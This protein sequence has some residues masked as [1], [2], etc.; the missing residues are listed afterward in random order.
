MEFARRETA[1]EPI[2][3]PTAG[4]VVDDNDGD[5]DTADV[6][7][8]FNDDSNHATPTTNLN[9]AGEEEEAENRAV[10]VEK[11]DHTGSGGGGGRRACG[12][13][14]GC[15][16]WLRFGNVRA[17]QGYALNGAAR[18]AMVMSNVFLTT[19][20]IYLAQ[21]EAGCLDHANNAVTV[22]ADCP[23][24]VYG[25]TPAALVANIAVASGVLSAC[26]MP[27]CGA[28]LDGTRHRW[29]AGV[30]AAALLVAVQVAQIGTAPATWFGM[31]LLQA[32][33][34]FFYQL[35]V[36]ATHAYLPRVARMVGPERMT[37]C[38]FFC[39]ISRRGRKR[40][41]CHPYIAPD[42]K[43]QTHNSNNFSNILLVRRACCTF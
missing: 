24:R 19:A 9:D 18:G 26:F 25:L 42:K 37:K 41:V 8:L 40:R 16:E 33:A 4:V 28:L 38:T 14:C 34:G 32:V 11:E 30:A 29:N 7:A 3:T 13:R 31:A 35:E 22:I 20:F 1:M 6:A 15:C 10:A 21:D 5:R 39:F 43:K 12:G 36:L 23:G 27:P 2:L 17:A